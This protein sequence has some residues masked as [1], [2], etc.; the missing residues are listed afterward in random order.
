VDE[1]TRETQ[2]ETRAPRGWAPH[3]R[4]RMLMTPLVAGLGGLIAFFTVVF[5]VV[6]LPIHT[7]DPPPSGDWAP[8]SNDARAGRNLFASNGCYVCHSGYT[9]PQDVRYALYFLY[10]KVSEPGD[11]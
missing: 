11:F 4:E 8:L 6:W 2:G 10:P 3:P 5:I 7:F 9:R 1:R